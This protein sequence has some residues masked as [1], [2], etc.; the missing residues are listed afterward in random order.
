MISILI[1]DYLVISISIWDDSYLVHWRFP[2][3]FSTLHGSVT[4]SPRAAVC[5]QASSLP[6]LSSSSVSSSASSSS[7]PRPG[8]VAPWG[9]SV[10]A[11][12]GSRRRKAAEEGKCCSSF[13]DL[14][15][16]PAFSPNFEADFWIGFSRWWWSS[17]PLPLS[18]VTSPPLHGKIFWFSHVKGLQIWNWRSFVM[19][20]VMNGQALHISGG[21][22]C[23]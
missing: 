19:S 14:F 3:L 6:Y 2:C 23:G 1:R 8:P 15:P 22:E 12:Q 13:F 20:G 17:P 16:T 21:V 9:T 7:S 10:Q 11:L 5:N 4:C 18:L